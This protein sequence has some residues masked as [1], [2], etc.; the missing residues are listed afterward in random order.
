LSEIIDEWRK[1]ATNKL[2]PYPNNPKEHPEE[3]I[4]K[5]VGSITEYGFV[6]PL[7]V[8]D[9][10]Q[11]IIGHG[12]LKAAKRI[13]MDEVPVI[14]ASHLTNAQQKALRLADN[15]I[16]ETGWDMEKLGTEFE[17]L[18]E[19]DFD[20]DF[21]G[22]DE[23]EIEDATG[24]DQRDMPED[25]SENIESKYQV[26]VDFDTESAA[27]DLYEELRDRGLSC[28]VSIL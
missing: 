25:M 13:G 27:D 17:G 22:F 7:V 10:G 3:Q 6:Q 4:D 24:V 16:A 28:R 11:V 19:M 9:E 21:T 5:L 1:E 12:R 20:L 26:I 15:R 14:E 23:S 18:D 8:N 2:K